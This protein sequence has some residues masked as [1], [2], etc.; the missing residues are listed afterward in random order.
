VTD[1]LKG[2]ND[3][4]VIENQDIL[5]EALTLILNIVIPF[6]SNYIYLYNLVETRIPT[7]DEKNI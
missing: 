2:N 3:R 6:S 7:V 1:L 4:E 5:K